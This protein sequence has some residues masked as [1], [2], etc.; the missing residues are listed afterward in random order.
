MSNPSKQKGTKFETKIVNDLNDHFGG[1]TV[2]G[3]YAKRMPAG[4]RYDIYNVRPTNPGYT[5]TDI[6]VAKA[7]YGPPLVTLRWSDFLSL[8]GL[9]MGEAYDGPLHIE[10]KRLAKIAL[11]SIFEEKFS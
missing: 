2:G 7:D 6:L 8:W 10:A 11:H 5:P 1:A 3:V 4:S 9:A